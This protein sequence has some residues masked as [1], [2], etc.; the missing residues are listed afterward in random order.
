MKLF[1]VGFMGSG[2]SY[3]GKI[4]AQKLGFLFVDLDSLIEN[5]EG[6]PVSEIFERQ[7]ETYFRNIESERLQGLQKWDEVV[8][9]TGG[10]AACFNDNMKWMN[11]NGITIYLKTNPHLLLERLTPEVEKR[12]LLRGKSSEELLD[13]IETKVSE[14]EQFYTQAAIIVEQ[15][16]DGDAIVFDILQKVF[17]LR[18]DS[19]ERLN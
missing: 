3:L 15:N 7:G 14:R 10:G 1:L 12:P 11:E 4:L 18:Q 5:T 13:F 6:G 8:I 17:L 19:I 9:A 2:K 16:E